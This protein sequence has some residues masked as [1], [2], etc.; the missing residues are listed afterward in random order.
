MNK[1]KRLFEEA[2]TRHTRQ[3]NGVPRQ[4]EYLVRSAFWAEEAM[5]TAYVDGQAK[6]SVTCSEIARD[7]WVAL[8]RRIQEAS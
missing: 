4:L 6:R 1:Y 7:Y 2:E 5:L 8:N 3:V